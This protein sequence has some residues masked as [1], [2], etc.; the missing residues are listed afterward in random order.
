MNAGSDVGRSRVL[1]G[2][3]VRVYVRVVGDDQ[4]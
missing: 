4:Y 1:A 3:G 2:V